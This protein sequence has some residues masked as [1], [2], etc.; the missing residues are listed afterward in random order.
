MFRWTRAG[1]IHYVLF[2]GSTILLIGNI[3]IVTGGLLQAVVL[4]ARRRGPLD[5]PRRRSRT[6]SPSGVLAALGYLFVRRLVLRPTRLTLDRTGLLILTMIASSSSTE[7]FAQA[8]E[9]AAYGDIPGAVVANALAVPLRASAHGG[10]GGRVRRSSG[11]R[12]CSCSP[13]SCCSSPR[14]STSTSYTSFVNVWFRKLGP[15]R[16]AAEDGPRG[17]DGHVRAADAPGPRLEGRP[18]R[19]HLHRMRTLPGG[20]PGLEHG[21]VAQPQDLHHGHPGHV[22]D[23]RADDRPHPQLTDRARD[24]RAR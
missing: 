11:G 1:V 5:V 21:Q 18:R 19:L 20:V 16:R 14:T 9:V 22:R 17:R 2:L 4:V 8:F 23:G 24:L 13:R 12:T 15:T 6:S 3:N 7:F 10:H